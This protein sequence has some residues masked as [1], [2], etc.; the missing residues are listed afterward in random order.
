MS[1]EMAEETNPRFARFTNKAISSGKKEF[2]LAMLDH[3]SFPLSL[4]STHLHRQGIYSK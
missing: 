1:P 2:V 4:L 3:F